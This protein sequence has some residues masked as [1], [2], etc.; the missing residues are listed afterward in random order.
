MAGADKWSPGDRVFV[1]SDATGYDRGTVLAVQGAGPGAH[2]T[3]SLD[4]DASRPSEQVSVPASDLLLL[5]P[6][7]GGRKGGVA[8]AT[9]DDLPLPHEAAILHE[10]R[11]RFEAREIYS[12]AGPL[13]VALNP[14]VAVP[15]LYSTARACDALRCSERRRQAGS[16][17]RAD[18]RPATHL[19][20]VAQ[21]AL[22]R[23]TGAQSANASAGRRLAAAARDE[24]IVVCGESGAGKTESTKL[25]LRYLALV[26]SEAVARSGASAFGGLPPEDGSA[27]SPGS[28]GNSGGSGTTAVMSASAARS[29]TRALSRSRRSRGGSILDVLAPPTAPA[30]GDG[31]APPPAAGVGRARAVDASPDGAPGTPRRPRSRRRSSVFA[32]AEAELPLPPGSSQRAGSPR[33]ASSPG[34]ARG[35]EGSGPGA[36]AGESAGDTVGEVASAVLSADPVLEAFGNAATTRNSNSSRFGKHLRLRFRRGRT[37]GEP[38]S[39]AQ[40]TPG[41]SSGGGSGAMLSGAATDCFLLETMRVTS[42][43]PGGQERNFHVFYQLLHGADEAARKASLVLPGETATAFRYLSVGRQLP[44]DAADPQAAESWEETVASLDWLGVRGERLWGLCRA[45]TGVLCLGNVAFEDHGPASPAGGP[46]GWGRVAGLVGSEAGGTSAAGGEEG[47][48]RHPLVRAA[49]ALGLAEGALVGLLTERGIRAGAAAAGSGR[50]STIRKPLSAGQ[51]AAMRDTLARCVYGA[52]FDWVVRE[53]N[54]ATSR[55]ASGAA[56]EAAADSV[57]GSTPPAQAGPASGRTGAGSGAGSGAG[58]GAGSAVPFRAGAPTDSPAEEQVMHVGLVDIFGFEDLSPEGLNGLDQ[59]LINFANERLQ[60]VCETALFSDAMAQAQAQGVAPEV[61]GTG[62]RARVALASPALAALSGRSGVLAVLEDKT[63]LASADSDRE[64]VALITRAPA[65]PP[66]PLAPGR[67]DP[68]RGGARPPPP[69]K[70]SAVSGAGSKWQLA[71]QPPPPPSGPA[72]DR[73]IRIVAPIEGGET[74]A[75]GLDFWV[76]HFA[77]DVRYCAQDFTTVNSSTGAALGNAQGL[78]LGLLA[79]SSSEVVRSAAELAIGPP[80]ASKRAGGAA[81]AGS[82]ASA[83]AASSTVSARFRRALEDVVTMLRGTGT[84]FVRCVKT[85]ALCR[86][87]RFDGALVLRQ[88]RSSGIARAMAARAAAFTAVVPFGAAARLG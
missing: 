32:A 64:F 45:L 13:L 10:L 82:A 15:G 83:V 55:S 71:A 70:G 27:V 9:L 81:G 29:H 43:A 57:T 25:L 79:S 24:T 50:A 26:G 17:A 31:A 66:A 42:P 14:F 62:Q 23:A 36:Q 65:K 75:R 6:P 67:A 86:P 87:F 22:D 88:L 37:S 21:R 68:T 69:P 61:L 12:A 19:F 4:E 35:G 8:A 73:P 72:T 16:A 85:N 63:R 41:T 47:A 46:S 60:E 53:I 59:L 51:A 40:G 7:R 11:S 80:A 39:P 20:D 44:P 34:G 3:V 58:A 2:V 33:A 76:S 28:N 1:P 49:E 38:S 77:G 54:T 56:T 18:E 5:L 78:A 52:L 84:Q 30:S 48:V 74:A